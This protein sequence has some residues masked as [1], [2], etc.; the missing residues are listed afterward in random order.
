M[1]NCIVTEVKQSTV[2]V[3]NLCSNQDQIDMGSLKFTD[4]Q[5]TE[6]MQKLCFN[7]CQIHMR[8]VLEI[9]QLSCRLPLLSKMICQ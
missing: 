5:S 7:L 6:V 3:K 1:V 9:L 2:V 8:S 4:T